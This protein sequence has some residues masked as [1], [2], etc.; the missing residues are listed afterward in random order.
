MKKIAATLIAI[1][2]G[3]TAG[4]PAKA[5]NVDSLQRFISIVVSDYDLE[6]FDVSVAR[7]LAVGLEATRDPGTYLE[8][9]SDIQLAAIKGY[10]QPTSFTSD[11]AL[12]PSKTSRAY[13]TGCWSPGL[14]YRA[15]NTFGVEIWNVA[16][17]SSFCASGGLIKSVT[18]QGMYP[19][20]YA[21][22]W[23]AEGAIAS[24][25]VKGSRQGI[26]YGQYKMNYN[27]AGWVV[28]SSVPCMRTLVSGDG[29][30]SFDGVCGP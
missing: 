1:L 22:G 12:I 20:I 13:P 17:K 26:V 19:T 16:L 23:T 6:A 15:F 4:T 11:G 2:F 21:W 10:L 7:E 3:L 29:S 28:S 14:Y 5:S 25:V 30:W 24:G 27:V 8:Q 9:L 18:Y